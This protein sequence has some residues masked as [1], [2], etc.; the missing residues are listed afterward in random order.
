VV[1]VEVQ[2]T[3]K[4]AGRPRVRQSEVVVVVEGGGS[5]EERVIDPTSKF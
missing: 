2:V 1:V 5:E 3:K 4:L